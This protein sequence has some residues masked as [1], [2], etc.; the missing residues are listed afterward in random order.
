[1]NGL[2]KS[3]HVLGPKCTSVYCIVKS[4]L[5]AYN[6]LDNQMFATNSGNKTETYNP[7]QTDT[8]F[9]FYSIKCPYINY[10]IRKIIVLM[11]PRNLLIH[12]GYFNQVHI[13]SVL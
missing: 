2:S 7:V 8:E 6:D 3:G 1:M 10:E 4:Q 9:V 13:P 5:I 12:E 11:V